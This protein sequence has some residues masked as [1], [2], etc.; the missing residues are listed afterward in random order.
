MCRRHDKPAAIY[1]PNSVARIIS[2]RREHS[3]P[4]FHT[5]EEAVRALAVSHEQY[6]Y[7][8]RKEFN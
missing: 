8:C 5:M 2:V 1:T 3:L 7:S 4:M 6:R